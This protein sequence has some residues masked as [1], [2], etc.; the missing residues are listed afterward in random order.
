MNKS[1]Y[2]RCADTARAV[3][4]YELTRYRMNPKDWEAN[5]YF[6]SVEFERWFTCKPRTVR[7]IAAKLPSSAIYDYVQSLPV[8]TEKELPQHTLKT[9]VT[10]L[11]PIRCK[12]CGFLIEHPNTR[13][14][15]YCLH[16]R[17]IIDRERH[18]KKR[19]KGRDGNG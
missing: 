12:R 13:Q 1:M 5:S 16:C 8:R 7:A 10:S 15:R 19:H 2:A 9:H 3:C 18:D 14:Q 11:P 17:Q 4:H 6:R